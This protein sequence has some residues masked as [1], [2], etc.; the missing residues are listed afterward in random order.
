MQLVVKWFHF[1]FGSSNILYSSV[2]KSFWLGSLRFTG[3]TTAYL[4]AW[5]SW[6]L[7]LLLQLKY[8]FSKHQLSIAKVFSSV[9]RKWKTSAFSLRLLA[10][11]VCVSLIAHS[12][13]CSLLLLSLRWCCIS[14]SWVKVKERFTVFLQ[15]CLIRNKRGIAEIGSATK[16]FW[17]WQNSSIA[18]LYCFVYSIYGIHE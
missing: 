6:S 3:W 17:S 1:L 13:K 4:Q 12:N 9:Q 18:C 10:A 16:I 5:S 15:M 14:Q 7:S 8:G 2:N 11:Y